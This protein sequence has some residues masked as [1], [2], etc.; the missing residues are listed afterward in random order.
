MQQFTRK[1]DISLESP[2]NTITTPPPEKPRHIL[3]YT[4]DYISAEDSNLEREDFMRWGLQYIEEV[5]LFTDLFPRFVKVYALNIFKGKIKIKKENRLC[6]EIILIFKI[7][8]SQWSHLSI[9]GFSLLLSLGS[10]LAVF[11][12]PIVSVFMP[13]VWMTYKGKDCTES[14]EKQQQQHSKTWIYACCFS[15]IRYFRRVGP[16]AIGRFSFLSV[17]ARSTSVRVKGRPDEHQLSQRG[18]LREADSLK[19]LFMLF[20]N[21]TYRL[22]ISVH[23]NLWH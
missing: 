15:I 18:W 7:R 3:Q 8:K 16:K 22:I 13:D 19:R 14:K 23:N 2:P 4:P 5:I 9:N 17:N 10:P 11:T 12:S 1:V 21:F 20:M 6:K